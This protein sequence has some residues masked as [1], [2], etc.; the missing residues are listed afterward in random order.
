MNLTEESKR[1]LAGEIPS[2][3]NDYFM[4]PIIKKWEGSGFLTGI[5]DEYRR[6]VT[7]LLLE[8]EA[9]HLERLDE[10]TR[11]FMVGPFTKFIFPTVR[12]SWPQLVAYNLVS[13]QPMTSPIGAIFFWRYRHGTTKGPTVA[14]TEMIANFDKRYS[15]EDVIGELVVTPIPSVPFSAP[16]TKT[17]DFKPVKAGTVRVF[18]DSRLIAIDQ[19]GGL[20]AQAGITLNAANSSIDYRTG[21]FS[22]DVTAAT[23]SI[24]GTGTS[25][26]ISYRFDSEL[27]PNIPQVNIDVQ[28]IPVEAETHKLK[29]LWSSEAAEDLRALHGGDIEAELVAGIANEISLE[30]DRTILSDLMLASETPGIE[31][32][33][34]PP[35]T[36]M[37]DARPPAAVSAKDHLWSFLVSL[38]K[39]ANDIQKKSLRGVANWAVTSPDIS[40]LLDATPYFTPDAAQ[41]TYS[42]AIVKVGTVQSRYT[43]YKDPMFPRNKI[44]MGFLGPTFLDAGYVFAPYIPLQVTPTFLDPNNFELRKA[45]RTRYGRR[46]IRPEFFGSVTVINIEQATRAAEP[47]LMSTVQQQTP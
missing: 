46:L 24:S 12:R 41:M 33:P 15:S 30:V 44:L 13:I 25:L 22:I 35:S 37:F 4:R 40:S 6:R 27:N 31:G 14:G 45:L 10:E 1:A 9:Q 34:F 47:I 19:N 36:A 38:N 23:P 43:V 29:A 32:N 39:V 16:V 2:V 21:A 11:A 5:G 42:G 17:L 18:A 7:A 3:A 26:T 28:R 20:L 8:N